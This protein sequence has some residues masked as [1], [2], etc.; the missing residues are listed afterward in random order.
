MLFNV[1]CREIWSKEIH[2]FC[3]FFTLLTSGGGINRR[4]VTALL[5]DSISVVSSID[6]ILIRLLLF[7]LKSQPSDMDLTPIYGYLELVRE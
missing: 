5:I 4:N 2:L 1:N 3:S 7:A 6:N